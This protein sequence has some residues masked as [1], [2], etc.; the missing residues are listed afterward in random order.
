MTF[1]FVAARVHDLLTWKN[2]SKPRA[3]TRSGHFN[4]SNL[5][6]SICRARFPFFIHSDA[7]RLKSFSIL[8]QFQSHDDQSD[9]EDDMRDCDSSDE[10]VNVTQNA[11]GTTMG[12]GRSPDH[13]T[14]IP[15]R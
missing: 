15:L 2:N 14:D 9:R 1:H 8:I 10:G 12:Y 3:Y 13:N 11:N 4:W 5:S 6:K 7:R